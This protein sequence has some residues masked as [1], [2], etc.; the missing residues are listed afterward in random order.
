[1]KHAI[2]ITINGQ[3][4]TGYA[5]ISHTSAGRIVEQVTCSE[6]PLVVLGTL[7][8]HLTAIHDVLYV[9][10][11]YLGNTARRKHSFEVGPIE[12]SFSP[13]DHDR[14]R[15]DLTGQTYMVKLVDCHS[16]VHLFDVGTG[17]SWVAMDYAKEALSVPVRSSVVQ[18]VPVG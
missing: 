6:P 3:S 8:D 11:E 1:M 12:I 18:P 15:E 2:M 7:E 13:L 4:F 17:N 16:N 14:F 5:D 10:G 9:I